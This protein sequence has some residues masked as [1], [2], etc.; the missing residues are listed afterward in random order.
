MSQVWVTMWGLRV[1]LYLIEPAAKRLPIT[2]FHGA[3]GYPGFDFGS[4]S[5]RLRGVS[6][7]GCTCS[8]HNVILSFSSS[9]QAKLEI[10]DFELQVISDVAK[11]L[12]LQ[13]A[14]S[15]GFGEKRTQL[16]PRSEAAMAWTLMRD[17]Q[18]NTIK[19]RYTS[20]SIPLYGLD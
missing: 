20:Y 16:I 6:L 7:P 13:A 3:L 8:S 9:S 10:A 5:A 1:F 19:V 14:E 12:T 18:P 2:L 17:I 11:A 4:R 15:A